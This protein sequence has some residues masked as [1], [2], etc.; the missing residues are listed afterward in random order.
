MLEYSEGKPVRKR[1]T[2]DEVEP[3][4]T[5]PQWRLKRLEVQVTDDR[6]RPWLGT[7][8]EKQCLP[9]GVKPGETR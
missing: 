8:V 3:A 2:W 6:R 5:H 9:Q 1:P 7:L 4:I